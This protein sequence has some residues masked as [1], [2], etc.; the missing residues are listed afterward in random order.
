VQRP[1]EPW[2]APDRKSSRSA[3]PE[4]SPFAPADAALPHRD[5]EASAADPFPAET[6]EDAATG[7]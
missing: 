4:D 1:A 5:V 2:A 7:L 6:E 3:R